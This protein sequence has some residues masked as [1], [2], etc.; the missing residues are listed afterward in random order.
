MQILSVSQT[1][2]WQMPSNS[3][4]LGL[5]TKE[6]RAPFLLH[7]NTENSS[8]FPA[9]PRE[10]LVC[11]ELLVKELRSRHGKDINKYP[12]SYT[13]CIAPQPGIL[14]CW[15]Y[16]VVHT[17]RSLGRLRERIRFLICPTS[18]WSLVCGLLFNS[19]PSIHIRGFSFRDIFMKTLAPPTALKTDSQQLS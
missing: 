12:L 13:S 2:T 9:L 8:I 10:T 16:P 18:A 7:Q 4:H 19:T 11:S 3:E 1:S 17:G 5:I 15:Y 14:V 6:Q